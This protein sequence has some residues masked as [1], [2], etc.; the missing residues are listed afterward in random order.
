MSAEPL[1]VPLARIDY[2]MKKVIRNL[3][4]SATISVVALLLAVIVSPLTVGGIL[5]LYVFAFAFVPT[6]L[7]AYVV[8]YG[9]IYEFYED[10][11]RI[12]SR[13]GSRDIQYRDI[14]DIFI[15][16]YEKNARTRKAFQVAYLYIRGEKKPVK[17][18][19]DP[20]VNGRKLS[21]W[22]H[23]KVKG[24]KSD[25][26]FELP[27]PSSGELTP[28]ATGTNTLYFMDHAQV[29]TRKGWV[30]VPYSDVI[31]I[32]RS[33]GGNRVFVKFNIEGKEKVYSARNI[34]LKPGINLYIWLNHKIK[35]S[36]DDSNGRSAEGSS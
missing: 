17:L 26:D 20:V 24:N 8:R 9:K 35:K 10:F 11:M 36:I 14:T 27:P 7:F 1:G 22:L 25:S 12:D 15:R 30:D 29:D 4:I 18:P 6:V 31:S 19:R 34:E 3:K 32:W 2:S 23:D 21:R 5:L 16:N 28:I 33:E 13:G